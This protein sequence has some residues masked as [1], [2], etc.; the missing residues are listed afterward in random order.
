M[1]DFPR[2]GGGATAA[3]VWAFATRQLTGITGTPR[4]DLL[5]EDAT[6]EAG[7][8]TRKAK[9]DALLAA[10]TE[11]EGTLTA[12]G[13][14]QQL[15][16][17]SDNKMHSIEGDIDFTNMAGGDTVVIR[18]YFKLKVAGGWVKYGEETYTGAQSLPDLHITTKAAKYGIRLTLQQTGGVFRNFDYILEKLI[19]T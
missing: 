15:I 5:G 3:E 8:A 14:E 2:T 17:T 13:T 18:L 12:D 6:F 10:A 9:I 11:T 1:P 19:R 4:T 16:A 7:S